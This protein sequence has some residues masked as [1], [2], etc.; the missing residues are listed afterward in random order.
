M[1]WQNPFAPPAGYIHD[2]ETGLYY[3]QSRYYDPAMGRFLNADAFTSTGQGLTGN[4]MFAYCGNNPVNFQD[5]AGT[6]RQY[7]GFDSA[8]AVGS[9]TSA[10]GYN[11]APSKSNFPSADE[12]ETIN[13]RLNKELRVALSSTRTIRS[14]IAFASTGAGFLLKAVGVSTST[15]ITIV[16]IIDVSL[17]GLEL[18]DRVING[19]GD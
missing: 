12:K 10:A 7:V 15:I 3:L 11:H 6:M 1:E 8:G 5:C 18:L 14:D 17:W 2:Q 13:K 4:N 16:V 9:L 19:R